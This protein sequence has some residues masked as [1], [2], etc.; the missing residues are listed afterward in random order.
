MNCKICNQQYNIDSQDKAYYQR[1]NVPEPIY[2]PTCRQQRRLP[3][4][5]ERSLHYRKCDLCGKNHMSSYDQNVSFPVYCLDCYYSDNWDQLKSARNFDFSRSFFEQFKELQSVSPRAS[6]FITRGTIE[7]S[8]YIN[9]ATNMKNS[10]LVFAAF[11]S[12]DCMYTNWLNKCFNIC[13]CLEIFNS[14]K[15]YDCVTCD[16]C[17]NVKHAQDCRDCRDSSFLIDCIGC[18]DC[19]GCSNKRNQKYIFFNEQLSESEYK[20]KIDQINLINEKEFNEY[21]KRFQII[22]KNGTYKYYHGYNIEQSIGDYL[23]NCHNVKD[24]FDCN[25]VENSRYC[26]RVTDVKECYDYDHFGNY[27]SELIYE[28]VSC[29]VG[30]SNIKFCSQVWNKCSEME[31]CDNCL[32]GSSDC[33]GCCCLTKK[34]YC[35]LNKQYN[36]QEYFKLKE[37]IIEHMRKTEEYGIF[38]PP[39]LCHIPYNESLAQDFFPLIKEQALALGFSWHEIDTHHLP[40]G[41]VCNKCRK[42]FKI[43]DQEKNFYHDMKIK[44]PNMCWN[45]RLE[46]RL[47]RKNPRK[48]CDRQCVKCGRDIKTSYTSDR[49]EIVYCEQCFQKEIY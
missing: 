8:D 10:Y 2:C 40:S 19:F 29:G 47:S 38:F 12:E 28:S 36:K 33:F 25:G 48:L 9:A 30:S 16:N 6:L 17:Y 42:N 3:W 34:K 11:D 41:L 23:I 27:S 21:S 46:D 7:N 49:T 44:D 39:E 5:S 20:Q 45:C 26:S 32:N 13:D 22:K 43:I 15:C 37:K 1:I 24:S 4:R 18:A 31:Y 14:Q 35:I